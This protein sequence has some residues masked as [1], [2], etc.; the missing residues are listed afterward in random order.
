MTQDELKSIIEALLVVSGDPAPLKRLAQIVEHFELVR[1]NKSVTWTDL[2]AADREPAVA[3]SLLLEE[4]DTKSPTGW[5]TA[6]RYIPSKVIGN[7]PNA[8]AV[9]DISDLVQS[10]VGKEAGEY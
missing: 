7:V 1:D 6:A 2:D 9:W 5:Q 3:F 4:V 8:I 10:T